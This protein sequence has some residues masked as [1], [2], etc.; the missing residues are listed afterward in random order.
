M[1]S[2]GANC[3]NRGK[4]DRTMADERWI[5]VTE[6]LP[7]DAYTRDF[8]VTVKFDDSKPIV[9]MCTWGCFCNGYDDDGHQDAFSAPKK[10]VMDGDTYWMTQPVPMDKVVAWMPVPKPYKK[11]QTGGKIRIQR[12]TG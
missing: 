11:E 9:M 2:H 12:G 8:L 5:P 4:G 6:R 1:W 7:Q 10:C 3:R